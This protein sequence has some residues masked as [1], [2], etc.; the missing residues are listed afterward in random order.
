[1]SRVIAVGGQG[2]ALI[3]AAGSTRR[4]AVIAAGLR[5]PAGAGGVTSFNGRIGLITLTG[6]DVTTA[7]GYTPANNGT[8]SAVAFTGQYS[9]LAGRPAIPSSPADIGAAT[10][11]EG[12]LAVTAVQPAALEVALLDK[13]DKIPG[14]GLSQENYTTS[15]K[16]KLAGLEGSHF[17]GL[18]VSLAALQ[19]AIPAGVA[20]DYA[21]V[22]AGTGYDTVR[23]LW[24]ASD[25]DWVAAGSGAPL[26]AAQ[27]KTLYESNPDTNAYSD[28]EKAKLGGVAAGATVNATDAALRD[29]ATHSGT[30]LASTISDLVEVTQDMVGAMIVQ[31]DNVSVVYDDAAGTITISAVSGSAGGLEPYDLPAFEG[32]AAGDMVHVFTDGGVAKARKASASGTLYKAHGFVKAATTSGSTASVVPLGGENDALAGLTPGAEYFLSTS[33]TGGVQA[34]PPSASGQLRQE[35]GVAISATTLATVSGLTVELE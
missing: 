7:L 1:M 8:L 14:Q 12:S 25:D 16:T 35:L 26:T 5:G 4:P 9:D 2:S 27:V 6:S 23:H 22:D 29:R 13:V 30:Q 3:I 28:A 34:A 11:A 33:A 18:F 31:G 24:D 32:L 19:L 21:D 17:K 20:G 15:E 10:A